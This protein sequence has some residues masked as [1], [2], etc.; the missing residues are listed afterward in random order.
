MYDPTEYWASRPQ[1]NRGKPLPDWVASWITQHIEG[2]TL[3]DFGVGDGR[4][5]HLYQ[6]MQVTG[7]DIVERYR[8]AAETQ[9]TEH[10]I[11]YTHISGVPLKKITG[12]FDTVV[13]SKVLLHVPPE[14]FNSTLFHL[15]RIGTRVIIWDAVCQNEPHVFAHDYTNMKDAFIKG[16]QLLFYLENKATKP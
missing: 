8:E 16:N 6:G 10:G 4:L 2:R 7:F 9:A 14:A 1:P 5:L 3:F 11:D 15:R 12:E 13:A